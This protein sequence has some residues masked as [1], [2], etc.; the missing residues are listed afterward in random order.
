MLT[1]FIKPREELRGEISK[2]V[3]LAAP[4]VVI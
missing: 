2:L 3:S 1:K 4:L